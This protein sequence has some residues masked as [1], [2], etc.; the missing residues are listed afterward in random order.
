MFSKRK[1][2]ADNAAEVAVGTVASSLT[3]VFGTALA[4]RAIGLRG[5]LALSTVPRCITTPLAIAVSGMIGGEPSLSAGMVVVTGLLGANFGGEEQE[6]KGETILIKHSAIAKHLPLFASLLASLFPRSFYTHLVEDN[7]PGD[8]GFGHRSE[9]PR[10]GY[11]G[12]QGRGGRVPVLSH[13][14]GCC[15]DVHHCCGELWV[16]EEGAGENS[17]VGMKDLTSGII[18]HSNK[19]RKLYIYISLPTPTSS[20]VTVPLDSMNVYTPYSREVP[21]PLLNGYVYHVDQLGRFGTLVED[22]LLV[23]GEG[24]GL[25]VLRTHVR[26]LVTQL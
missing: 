24:E 15:G 6:R 25:T 17:Y 8:T 3:G 23:E 18:Y 1:L 4:A 9:Q 7:G 12:H 20:S 5:T 19:Q 21:E 16:G 14:H 11:G 2:V 26:H 22:V 13:R 10:A